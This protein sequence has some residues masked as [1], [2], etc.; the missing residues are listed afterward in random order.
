[1]LVYESGMNDNGGSE[2]HMFFGKSIT[3]IF[4]KVIFRCN[5]CIFKVVGKTVLRNRSVSIISNNCCGADICHTY[6]MRFN[7]P[8]VNLQILPCD[9]PK[10]CE[11][12]EHY[13]D[14]EIIEITHSS[15]FLSP[16]QKESIKLVYNGRNIEDLMEFP[17]GMCD[18]ILIAFQHYSSFSEARASWNRRK[19]RVNIRNCAFLLVVDS[20]GLK[21]ARNFEMINTGKCNKAIITVNCDYIPSK[22]DTL[23][24][25]SGD[26]PE[27]G[28]FMDRENL[29]LKHYE[30]NFN[31]VKWLNGIIQE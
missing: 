27:G 21:D 2:A 5:R 9:F 31:P 3:E 19:H 8:T 11:N 1:M 29:L 18:D 22:K 12:L 14:S 30:V 17:F 7:S 26:V 15:E 6:G 4:A 10:F 28:H 25:R 23:I 24:V 16:V 13:L 20:T